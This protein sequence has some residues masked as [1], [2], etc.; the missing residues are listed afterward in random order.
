MLMAA[1]QNVTGLVR[2][3]SHL[4]DVIQGVGHVTI[5]V[6]KVVK[7]TLGAGHGGDV[8]GR[9]QAAHANLADI[10]KRGA[11][12]VSSSSTAG[13]NTTDW[14]MWQQSLPPIMSDAAH[15]M[16]EMVRRIGQSGSDDDEFS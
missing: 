3:N 11:G 13:Y 8:I 12:L 10:E 16:K 5:L 7:E 9:L 6:D 1:I 14:H 4:E 2:N 15:E